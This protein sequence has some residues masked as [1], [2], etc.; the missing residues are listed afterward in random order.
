MKKT[1]A[2]ASLVT[3]GLMLGS[4]ALGTEPSVLYSGMMGRRDGL[5][6]YL[7]LGQQYLVVREMHMTTNYDMVVRAS[8]Y[9][10][11]D[12]NRSVVR[13]LNFTLKDCSTQ[14]DVSDMGANGLSS[15]DSLTLVH[16]F[17]NKEQ[18][19]MEIEHFGEGDLRITSCITSTNKDYAFCVDTRSYGWPARGIAK[20]K[21]L[22]LIQWGSGLYTNLVDAVRSNVAPV[23]PYPQVK[24]A[25]T[26]AEVLL[27]D[28]KK[29]GEDVDRALYTLGKKYG[30]LII[31]KTPS[32]P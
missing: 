11:Y 8:R 10:P 7:K 9:V 19:I 14:V 29:G 23:L 21:T 16:K 25:L 4:A 31:P 17:A 5:T 24:A 30:P 6:E 22:P 15:G 27:G 3:S 32:K 26:D 18:L 12:T 13:G 2:L 20:R 1:L 28:I